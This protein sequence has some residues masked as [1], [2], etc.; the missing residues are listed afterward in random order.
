MGPKAA[1]KSYN[2]FI[3]EKEV[4]ENLMKKD[5]PTTEYIIIQNNQLHARNAELVKELE[6]IKIEMTD[7]EEIIES[8]EKSKTCLTGY[9]KNQNAELEAYKKLNQ[10]VT[11]QHSEWTYML[12][13][14]LATCCIYIVFIYCDFSVEI[15]TSLVLS[16][17]FV[18]L[19][20][21]F[22]TSRKINVIKKEELT[23]LDELKSIDMSNDYL[24]DIIDNL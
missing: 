1:E 9:V 18:Q 10:V 24:D 15:N 3:S 23:I 13:S 5:N 12:Y 21:V 7:K 20:Y 16:I 8:L 19:S 4:K 2:F 14:L 22:H 6:E 11:R 17:F